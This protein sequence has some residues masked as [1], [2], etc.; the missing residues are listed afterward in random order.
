M[1]KR[2]KALLSGA[3]DDALSH[4]FEDKQIAAAALLVEAA[5]SDT[6][7]DDDE[8]TAIKTALKRHFDL[9]DTETDALI[10]LGTDHQS[11]AIELHRFTRTIKDA[12]D[13]EERIILI[14]MLWEVVL[15]DGVLH[16]YEDQLLRRIAG[17]LYV[18]DRERGE[19]R[20]RVQLKLADAE[21]PH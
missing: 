8:R 21:K 7:I 20:Q 19:A 6:G 2:L 17:L 9:S 12:F 13:H 10:A 5:L 11:N 1:L 3:N 18:S 16:H 15:A 4:G 14:E